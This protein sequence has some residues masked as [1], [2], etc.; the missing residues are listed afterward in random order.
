MLVFEIQAVM[1]RIELQRI[2]AGEHF[3]RN[4]VRRKLHFPLKPLLPVC[5]QR[6]QPKQEESHIPSYNDR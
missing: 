2:A 4:N 3:R 1:L 6:Q 5:A